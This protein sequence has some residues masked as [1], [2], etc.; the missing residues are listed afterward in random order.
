MLFQNFRAVFWVA[1]RLQLTLVI[2]RWSLPG[3]GEKGVPLQCWWESKLVQPGWRKPR[4]FLQKLKVEL[5]YDPA[6]PLLG[7]VLEK[8]TVQKDTCTPYFHSSTIC[9]S[10]DMEVT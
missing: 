2:S 4:R 10:Q 9:K 8:T 1:D 6:I 5:Q 7:I 3:C